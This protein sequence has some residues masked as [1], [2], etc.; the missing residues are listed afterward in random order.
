MITMPTMAASVGGRRIE[1][2]AASSADEEYVLAGAYRVERHERA[3]GVRADAVI[4]C[5][6]SSVVPC[7]L[8][9]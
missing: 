6:T 9:S 4:G 1:G 8:A 7:R 5:R 2:M 3:A